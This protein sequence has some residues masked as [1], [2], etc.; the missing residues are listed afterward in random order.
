MMIG[1][2]EQ[3]GDGYEMDNHLTLLAA[4]WADIFLLSYF[5]DLS[6]I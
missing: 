5:S 1:D 2:R 3:G 6:V 4:A